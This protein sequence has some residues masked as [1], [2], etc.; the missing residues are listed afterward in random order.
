MKQPAILIG[1]PG[2]G[3][4]TIG[5]LLA[6]AL[7]LGFLD[8]DVHIQSREGRRLQDILDEM[9]IEAF[10][11]LEEQYLFEIDP[12]GLVLATGGSAVYSESAMERFSRMGAIIHLDLDYPLLVERIR[13]LPTRGVVMAPGQTL[14]DLF[15]DRLPLYRR[16]A[17]LTVNCDGKTQEEIVEEIRNLFHG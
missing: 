11:R 3:K 16:W 12:S 2:V 15:D 13:D 5:V 6:K 4:S 14:R 10:C 1:M 8:T 9:G 7:S 17:T